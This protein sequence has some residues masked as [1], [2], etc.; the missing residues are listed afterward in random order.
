M[1]KILDDFTEFAGGLSYNDL[2]ASIVTA[3][4]ERLLD[5]LGCA[6]GA[7]DCDTAE[8][9]RTL[10][11]P[12]AREDLAGRMLGSKR[13]YAADAAAFVNS[14]MIRNLD[15][16][17]TYPGGHP[18]DALGALF[19]VAPRLRV[20]GEHLITTA[21]IAYEIFIRLQMKAQL[22]ERGWDQGFGISVG[23]AAGLARLMGLDRDAI[24]HAIAITAVANMPMRATRAGQLSMWKGAATAYAVRNA[25][26]GVQLAAAG[27][28][29]PE[30]PFTGRHG[31]TEQ[32]SGPIEL[33]AFGT[34][35]E[36]FF[37]PRAKIKYWPVVYNMQALVWAA[38]ELRRKVAIEDLA[39][40][41]V[42]TYWS[43]WHES[44]S[45]P[46]KWNPTTR[47]T[48]DHSLPYI[49]AWTMRHGLIDHHAFVPESY[50][51]PSIRPLMN[52]I[53]V[54]ID[55]E[56]EKQFP[57]VVSMRV[58]AKDRAG[59]SYEVTVINPLGHEDNPVSAQDL[60][61]KFTRLC[62]PRLGRRRAAAALKRWQGMENESDARAVFDAVVVKGASS[63]SKYSGGSR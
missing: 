29:G 9:G 40:V 4:K 26:F 22:R 12:P 60:A 17:D 36:D 49:F 25:V 1:D 63:I 50:L 11:G 51:D 34:T 32:V 3:G 53:T 43:A 57:Q 20:S 24:R 14:C 2:P 54:H 59:K 33:P 56:F 10:A 47:E 38:I 55:D 61:D 44:G 15:F 58:V 19:A 45:E 18:S 42:Q 39:S 35:A 7:Y 5:A 21:V 13:L 30:A 37:I 62:E 31:L 48:A 23:A 27:M 16:N 28:N 52:L 8:V 46:A 41:D 6:L